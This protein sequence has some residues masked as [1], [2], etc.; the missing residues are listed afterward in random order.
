MNLR[1]M[2]GYGV[3]IMYTPNFKF[4]NNQKLQGCE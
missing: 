3:T 4:K 1:W 2:G